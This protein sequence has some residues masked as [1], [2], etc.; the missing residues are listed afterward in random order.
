MDS[1]SI[2]IDTASL[3]LCSLTGTVAMD[4]LAGSNAPST[5]ISV[6]SHA[7]VAGHVG[8]FDIYARGHPIAKETLQRADSTVSI[9]PFW[10]NSGRDFTEAGKRRRMAN[11]Y[12]SF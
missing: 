10:E 2:Q 11:C 8:L 12:G 5:P 1:V 4:A 7:R 6:I 3:I 9:P